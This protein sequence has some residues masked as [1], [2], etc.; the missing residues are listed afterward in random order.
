VVK[1]RVLLHRFLLYG[2]LAGL[3]DLKLKDSH[4]KG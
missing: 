2:I 1:Q 4:L 3:P